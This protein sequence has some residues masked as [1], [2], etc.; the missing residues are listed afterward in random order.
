VEGTTLILKLSSTALC[1][2]LH[3]EDY[4]FTKYILMVLDLSNASWQ[5]S[6]AKQ[7]FSQ[8]NFYLESEERKKSKGG[9]LIV[10]IP[11]AINAS[12]QAEQPTRTA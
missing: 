12:K 1:L 10:I 6:R 4:R 5:L 7:T 2:L 11:G 3:R 8:V 9:W